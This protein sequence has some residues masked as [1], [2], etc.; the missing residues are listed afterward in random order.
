[1]RNVLYLLLTG[2]SSPLQNCSLRRL[3]DTVRLKVVMY[4]T[5]ENRVED[6]KLTNFILFLN[7]STNTFF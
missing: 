5:F 3:D 1:M 6:M 2:I 7:C 4:Q